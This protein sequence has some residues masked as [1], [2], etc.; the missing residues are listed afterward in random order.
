MREITEK[1]VKLK[2]QLL[3]SP[4]H[5]KSPSKWYWKLVPVRYRREHLSTRQPP[6]F[7]L[8]EDL[9]RDGSHGAALLAVVHYYCPEQ[10]KLDGK[11]QEARLGPEAEVVAEEV[12][13]QA[14]SQASLFGPGLVR[15]ESEQSVA[16]WERGRRQA[17]QTRREGA[18]RRQGRQTRR[19]GP[20]CRQGRGEGPSRRQ[21]CQTRREGP[22]HRQ[23]GR[24]RGRTW[25]SKSAWMR[26]QGV[27]NASV[28]GARARGAPS[29][30]PSAR[31][32]CGWAVPARAL[33]SL[34]L[35]C[36]PGSRDKN[37]YEGQRASAY[38]EGKTH[39]RM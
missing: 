14:A 1:E 6:Y 25:L 15:R 32:V 18:R 2:Q 21:A 16:V 31:C 28:R 30:W 38:R 24:R 37:S 23:A 9:M 39:G 4:A 20:R 35:T 34:S 13:C 3:E 5:Q 26:A 7:P 22:R 17:R 27:E 10:M 11:T 8:L 19:E 29:P 12:S 36:P 33:F